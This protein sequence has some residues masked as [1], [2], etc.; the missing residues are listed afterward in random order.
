ARAAQGS[1]SAAEA[2][3]KTLIDM[4]RAWILVDTGEITDD[5]EPDPSVLQFLEVKPVVKNYG[6]TPARIIKGSIRCH[7]VATVADLPSE[8]QYQGEHV[9][10]IVLPPTV[11]I[12][13]LQVKIRASDFIEIR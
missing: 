4:E 8:P 13:P 3:I 9:M 5:F 11:V 7:Q 12:Q 10:D 1:A 2:N 6:R